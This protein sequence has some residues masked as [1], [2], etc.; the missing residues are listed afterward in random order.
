MRKFINYIFIIVFITICILPLVC[1]N[2]QGGGVSEVENRELAV[3][4]RAFDQ[5]GNFNNNIKEEFNNW[6]ND[7][8]G[9]RDTMM[10]LNTK[11][12]F[13]LFQKIDSSDVI[14]GKN[15][16]LFYQGENGIAIS[17]Y[18]AAELYTEDELKK[19]LKNV[20]ELQKWSEKNGMEFVL[21][22]IPNK[23]HIY[24]D[25]MPDGIREIH[26]EKNIDLVVDYIRK[27]SNVKIVY[28]KEQ[29]LNKRE[30]QDVFYRYD[31]H[32][33][34]TGAYEGY[35][36]LMDELGIEPLS[37][38]NMKKIKKDDG[39]LSNMAM[40]AGMM[41]AYDEKFISY[42]G[43]VETLYDDGN[44]NNA[45]QKY[46]YNSGRGK[47]F[48]MGDSFRDALKPMLSR[49]FEYADFVHR[50]TEIFNEVL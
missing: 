28:P 34:D 4:P 24:S 3:F 29:L 31:T 18:Q 23:E 8:I 32:W 6:L 1:A 40:L 10:R 50:D 42:N 38:N 27:N 16:W 46:R 20:E 19:I 13:D 48:F 7:N 33:N 45:Y 21:M 49:T 15:N 35:K 30:S 43:T 25:Y 47:I 44:G 5:E 12:Q 11:V 41:E 22:L 2:K 39:D 36:C 9:F 37:F 17:D 26:K 14:L